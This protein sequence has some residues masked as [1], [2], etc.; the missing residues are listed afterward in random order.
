MLDVIQ[1]KNKKEEVRQVAGDPPSFMKNQNHPKVLLYTGALW[2][3]LTAG[4]SR[5]TSGSGHRRSC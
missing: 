1:E 3:L 5:S 2:I 4:G